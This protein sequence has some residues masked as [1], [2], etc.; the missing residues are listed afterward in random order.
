ML[1]YIFALGSLLVGLIVLFLSGSKKYYASLEKKYGE[2]PAQKM[3]RSLKIWGFFFLIT[4]GI[5]ILTLAFEG[6]R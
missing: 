4:S 5:L 6:A 2:A 3:T 1:N